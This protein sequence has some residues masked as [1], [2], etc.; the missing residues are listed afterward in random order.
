[1]PLFFIYEPTRKSPHPAEARPVCNAEVITSG[2]ST[3]C[4]QRGIK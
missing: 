2:E 3:S 4:A 1:M